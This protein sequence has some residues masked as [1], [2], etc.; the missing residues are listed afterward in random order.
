MS[1]R[2]GADVLGGGAWMNADYKLGATTGA[3]AATSDEYYECSVTTTDRI[4]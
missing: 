1:N 2:R 3:V 4:E